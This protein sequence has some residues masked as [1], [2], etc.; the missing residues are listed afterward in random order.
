M[1]RPL[2]AALGLASTLLGGAW[3]TLALGGTLF[4]LRRP[5]HA[6]DWLALLASPALALP[7]CALL[8][9]VLL[10]WRA[11]HHRLAARLRARTA[12]GAV[13][14]M[15]TPLSAIVVRGGAWLLGYPSLHWLVAV[16]TGA[17]LA[18]L[19]C[20][21]LLALLG[22]P[23]VLLGLAPGLA[24]GLTSALLAEDYFQLIASTQDEILDPRMSLYTALMVG[25]GL[26]GLALLPLSVPTRHA[27]DLRMRPLGAALCAVAAMLLAAFNRI[28]LQSLPQ[29]HVHTTLA[30]IEWLCLSGVIGWLTLGAPRTR[31]RAR[32]AGAALALVPT[33]LLVT[34]PADGTALRPRRADWTAEMFSLLLVPAF[35]GD[36]DGYLPHW[37]GDVDCDDD[38]RRRRPLAREIPD[39][40][41]DDNCDGQDLPGKASRTSLSPPRPLEEQGPEADL[42]ILVTID[43]LRADYLSLYGRDRPTTPTLAALAREEAVV[44]EHAY[45]PGA[46]TTLSLPALL[47][48]RYPLSLDLEQ[49][50][51]TPQLRYV[52]PGEFDPSEHVPNQ[53]F[54]ASRSDQHPTLPQ[55]FAA[56][57]RQSFAAVDDGPSR[58]FTRG[59]GMEAGFTEFSFPNAP[60]GPG[61]EDW[62]RDQVTALAV[63][64]A[65]RAPEGSFFWIHY[66]D[67]HAAPYPCTRW[68]ATGGIGC[69][70]EAIWLVDAGIGALVERL[71]KNGRWARTFLA[72][73]AD[74]G[75]GLKEHHLKHHG[76][77]VFEELVRVPL[78]V[79][80]P[81]SAHG[82]TRHPIPVSGLDASATALASAGLPI[83][84]GFHG[85]DL[86]HLLQGQPRRVPVLAQSL[87]TSVLGVPYSQRTLLA[88]GTH[89]YMLDRVSRQSWLFDLATDPN[90]HA[91]LPR[92]EHE[93][94]M[95]RLE[96]LL[97]QL[98]AIDEV[99]HNPHTF[100][101]FP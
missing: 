98:E 34:L 32:W 44:F 49:V 37:L 31:A 86:R 55:I 10:A 4:L 18:A 13:L 24:L 54:A 89:R 67:P 88:D 40:G 39:N 26:C 100:E 93:T 7:A 77:E 38:D 25:G 69:Y 101:R 48:G 6:T 16:G 62:D 65:D 42:V 15:L 8:T 68:E 72:V 90:Q 58:V 36:G 82:G 66:Y 81:G 97:A 47:R 57:G 51:R 99:S 96:D 85:E 76:L 14:V 19:L 9:V 30:L 12:W 80:L 35:D 52:F 1:N 23:Q 79:K 74:H 73:T 33:A 28:T 45:S 70:D 91:P 64:L 41:I 5:S 84:S 43:Q 21:Y 71:R 11:L 78:L 87:L 95:R 61:E 3:L 94:W 22:P 63:D 59:L 92:S 29:L 27:G 2:G 50:Y 20:R 46:I 75:E 53:S 17:L 56:A 83:P 60:E